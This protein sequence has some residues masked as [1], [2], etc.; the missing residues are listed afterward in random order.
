L[1]P[2]RW[3]YRFII[4]PAGPPRAA[5]AVSGEAWAPCGPPPVRDP[6]A[7]GPR[8]GPPDRVAPAAGPSITII[9]L[10]EGQRRMSAGRIPEFLVAAAQRI[11]PD[12]GAWI[13]TTVD[14]AIAAARGGPQGPLAGTT[15]AV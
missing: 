15:F 12:S 14:A 10:A 7:A 5:G 13:T 9:I 6:V 2:I 8:P 1:R 4:C 11:D 3:V